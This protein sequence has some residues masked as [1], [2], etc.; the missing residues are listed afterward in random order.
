[1]SGTSGNDKQCS[2]Q[3]HQCNYMPRAPSNQA[4]PEDTA[5][6]SLGDFVF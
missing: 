5:R 6:K 2:G 3:G 1:M 4:D